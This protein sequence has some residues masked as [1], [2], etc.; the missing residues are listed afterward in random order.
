MTFIS[1]SIVSRITFAVCILSIISGNASGIDITSCANIMG[2]G[3]LIPFAD[4][5][6]ADSWR[7]ALALVVAEQI[8][9]LGVLG[10]VR[11]ALLALVYV[12]AVETVGAVKAGL[13]LTVVARLRLGVEHALGVDVTPVRVAR[14]RR[15]VRR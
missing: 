15:H 3:R 6:I 7:L 9:A 10:T 11:G 12:R 2:T 5:S 14:I 1:V 4:A 8:G 13:A